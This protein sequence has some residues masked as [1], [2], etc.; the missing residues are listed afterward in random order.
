MTCIIGYKH[1]GKTYIGGDSAYTFEED[2]YVTAGPEKVFSVGPYTFGAC[3]T[4]KLLQIIQ[5]QF[6]PPKPPAVNKDKDVLMKFLFTKFAPA[7][8]ELLTEYAEDCGGEVLG[9]VIVRVQNR[10]FRIMGDWSVWEEDNFYCIG[11][12]AWHATGAIT[13]LLGET[14]SGKVNPKDVI[15][16]ALDAAAKN[17]RSVLGP[18]YV[19]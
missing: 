7:L 18:F 2:D 9:E 11:S 19:K 6:T 3:G 10:L 8:K 4:M 5:Y 17:C 13:A 15:V 1:K 12:G 14:D 16:K